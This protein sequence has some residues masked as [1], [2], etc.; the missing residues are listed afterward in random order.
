MLLIIRLLIVLLFINSNIYFVDSAISILNL[1]FLGLIFITPFMLKDI[2]FSKEAVLFLT[3][4]LL[5]VLVGATYLVFSYD[6]IADVKHFYYLN[7]LLIIPLWIYSTYKVHGEKLFKVIYDTVYIMLILSLLVLFAELITN[8]H[9]PTHN[10]EQEFEKIPSGFFTNPNDTAAITVM[11]YPF[12]LFF[13]LKQNKPF[14]T[15]IITLVVLAINIICMSRISFLF[16]LLTPMFWLIVKRKYVLFISLSLAFAII[17][18]IIMNIELEYY[19][20]PENTWQRNVN[21][22][23]SLLDEDDARDLSNSSFRQRFALYSYP[24]KNMSEFIT[25]YGFGGSKVA[26]KKESSIWVKNPHSFVV[27]LIY[28]FGF[29][30]VLPFIFAIM[31][32]AYKIIKKSPVNEVYRYALIQLLYFLA[33]T[34]ISSSIIRKPIFWIPYSILMLISVVPDK[35]LKIV[36]DEV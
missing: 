33:L 32:L 19:K 12:I 31:F 1:F 18:G 22:F 8:L 24:V 14:K 13:G 23:A 5:L 35:K 3:L 9:L 4:N 28:D 17:A 15:L 16:F 36:A 6:D 10:T 29:L 21:R 2:K 11:L 34:N 20:N 7:Y 25:G 26:L 30:G 27:E